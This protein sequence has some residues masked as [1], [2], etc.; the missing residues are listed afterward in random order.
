MPILGWPEL[1]LILAIVLIVFG[2]SRLKG[3]GKAVGE[4]IR[5]FKKASSEEP[6]PTRKEDE[7]EAIFEA[8]RKMGVDT[9][10]KSME[11]I[12]NE[13]KEKAAKEGEVP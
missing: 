2:A 9:K 1:I 10:G 3:L 6:P 8:A 12:L 11:Q 7:K 13:M 5:E 4:S